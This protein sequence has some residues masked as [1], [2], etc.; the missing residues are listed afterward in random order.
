MRELLTKIYKDKLT[1]TAVIILA[2][3]YLGIIFA[4]FL[5]PY[6]KHFAD[7]NLSYAPPS[8][9]YIINEYG[10]LEAPYTY[11]WAKTFDSKNLT[12]SFHQDRSQ[13]YYLKYH[14]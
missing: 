13:K 4:D 12:I 9:I 6:D 11:N 1:L 8:N 14:L 7:R 5:A 3:L 2:V 10:K